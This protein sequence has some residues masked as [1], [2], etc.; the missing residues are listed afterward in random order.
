VRSVPWLKAQSRWQVIVAEIL[1]E[2]LPAQQVRSLWPLVTRWDAPSKTLATELEVRRMGR[3]LKRDGRAE[4][5]LEVAERLA[6]NPEKLDDD[7]AIRR[8]PGV[9]QSVAALAILAAPV[10]PESA[11]EE[12]VL[13]RRGVLRTVARFTGEQVDQRNRLTDGRVGVARM[14]GY[15]SDARKAHLGL[16][17]LSAAVCRPAE[18]EC[19]KCPLSESCRSSRATAQ[20]ESLLF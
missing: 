13:A 10:G 4:Q 8:I 17:E 20:Y 12:P 9:N 7:E 18:T 14:I 11:S 15:G 16:I 6:D 1:L 2:R 5:I 19:V 3:M